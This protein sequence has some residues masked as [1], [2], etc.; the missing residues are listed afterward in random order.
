MAT[1]L[2]IATNIARFMAS[3]DKAFAFV[4]GPASGPGSLI[5]TEAGNIP[6]LARLI[7]QI[8][9]SSNIIALNGCPENEVTT[10][11]RVGQLAR[12]V[13]PESGLIAMFRLVR[14]S[15]SSIWQADTP[16]IIYNATV[17]QYQR[18]VLS[19]AEGEEEISFQSLPFNIP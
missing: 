9:D 2:E 17:G 11:D 19:G 7:A 4:N 6:T 1:S 8:E 15:P 14:V 3:S 18:L 10:G 16:G 13:F 5:E 12:A